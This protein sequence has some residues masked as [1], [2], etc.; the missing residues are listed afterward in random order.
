MIFV[1][2]VVFWIS[3]GLHAM[4]TEESVV[5]TI[6]DGAVHPKLLKK[7][8]HAKTSF[9][10]Y[11]LLE[12][13]FGQPIFNPKN[14]IIAADDGTNAVLLYDSATQCKKKLRMNEKNSYIGQFDWHWEGSNLAVGFYSGTIGVYDCLI[15]AEAICKR[16]VGCIRDLKYRPQAAEVAVAMPRE[17]VKII[18]TRSGKIE[19]AFETDSKYAFNGISWHKGGNLLA[20]TYNN[21]LKIWDLR[22]DKTL[23]TCTAGDHGEQKLYCTGS[24]WHD[25]N[26]LFSNYSS[27]DNNA[28]FA[29]NADQA[30]YK[31][32]LLGTSMISSMA[33]GNTSSLL[34]VCL[35]LNEKKERIGS[36]SGFFDLTNSDITVLDGSDDLLSSLSF[37]KDK[38]KLAASDK[39]GLRIWDL[40]AGDS[41][42]HANI[43]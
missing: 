5:V 31:K 15:G 30:R 16:G 9:K 2:L 33:P 3:T 13:Y 8:R 27:V 32:Y 23:H 24:S 21:G 28:L 18:D 17:G 19:H 11:H 34:A 10:H 6:K 36:V 12:G 22:A 20:T 43:S 37:N 38:S 42:D 40:A 4:D 14:E 7:I 35:A 29:W 25:Q 41:N 26:L 1:F 39:D